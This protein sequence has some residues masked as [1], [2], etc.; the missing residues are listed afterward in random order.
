MRLLAL[1]FIAVAFAGF[2]SAK[3]AVPYNAIHGHKLQPKPLKT[4][5]AAAAAPKVL[6]AATTDGN[7]PFSLTGPKFVSYID[8]TVS[9]ISSVRSM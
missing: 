7:T 6:A 5:A 1:S 4:S 9:S 8:N 3:P 2:T